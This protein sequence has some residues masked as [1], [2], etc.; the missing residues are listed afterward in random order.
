V[1]LAG[2]TSSSAL[3]TRGSPLE[4]RCSLRRFHPQRVVEAIEVIE[5]PNRRQQLDDLAFVVMLPQLG[6]EL[7]VDFVG[8]ASDSLGELQRSLFGLTEVRAIAKIS[9]LLDLLVAPS[10]P[11]CQ[12]GMGGESILAAINLRSA[13]D[14]EFFQ[15]GRNRAGIHDRAEVGDHGAEDLRAMRHGAKHIGNLA[16]FRDVSVVDFRGFLIDL[17]FLETLNSWHE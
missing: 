17:F 1:P 5:Q 16:A 7:I 9:Q 6:P 12:G 8:I 2:S 13:N 3:P 4:S 14:Y 10:V 11:P 15:L